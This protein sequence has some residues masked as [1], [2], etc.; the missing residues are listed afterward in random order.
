MVI[1]IIFL[2]ITSIL[3]SNELINFFHLKV[4]QT[5]MQNLKTFVIMLTSF[6]LFFNLL[7]IISASLSDYPKYQKYKMQF[8]FLS[9]FGL[10]VLNFILNVIIYQYDSTNEKIK[11]QIKRKKNLF[12][13]G[14]R[15]WS[16]YDIALMG[17]FTALT[18]VLAYLEQF[19]PHMNNGG[20]IALKYIPII[21]IAFIHSAIGGMMVGGISALM[22]LI[23]IPT[24]MIVSPWSYLLDYFLPM[25]SPAITGLLRFKTSKKNNYLEYLNYVIIVVLTF[26]L[27]YLWQ[28]LSGYFIWVAL[29]GPGWGNNGWIY[30]MI[31]NAIH[32]WIFTYPLAQIVVPSILKI[33]SP[34]YQN[35]QPY[36]IY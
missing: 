15:K 9:L 25:I 29:Y 3:T 1:C 17:I 10:N 13:L 8:I 16:T 21:V 4:D 24:A 18:I 5:T 19:L 11:W 26:M 30:S 14:I 22:S 32:V 33:L 35:K 2:V 28:V 34:V 31:Y 36:F 27:V 6:G 20:G 7:Y 12:N 23:F